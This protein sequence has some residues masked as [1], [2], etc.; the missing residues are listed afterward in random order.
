MVQNGALTKHDAERAAGCSQF[1]Y[2][3]LGCSPMVRVLN[4]ERDALSTQDG[5]HKSMTL[6]WQRVYAPRPRP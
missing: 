3:A 6:G 5:V 4:P 2:V 1:Q